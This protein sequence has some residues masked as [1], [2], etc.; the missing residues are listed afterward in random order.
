M[1]FSV[2]IPVFNKARFVPAAV[3]S[4]LAQTLAPLEVIV[5][6]D[7]STDGSAQALAAIT[8]P[9]LRVL[10]QP[11]GGVSA[12]RNRGIDEAA[13]D[14]IAFL[15]AD[16]AYHPRFLE[17]LAQAHRL[18]PEAD[19]LATRFHTVREPTGQPFA[20]W[21][22]PADGG[23][24][25]RVDDLRVRWMRNACLCSSSVA[26][27]AARLKAMRP[28][29]IDGESHGE[30]LDMWFRIA[31]QAPVALVGGAF[32]TVRGEVPGSLTATATAR[33]GMPP[34][35][36]RMRQQ[37]LDG[38]LPPRHRASALWFIA[39]MQVTMARQALAEGRRGEALGWLL[40]ARG[41]GSRRW[42]ITL[43]MALA[44]PARAVDRWQRW[45]L[46]A[47]EPLSKEAV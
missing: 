21:P 1:K 37:A 46:R 47:A 32:A 23:P 25:E 20:P 27:R 42:W 4:A 5:I 16:D 45:R 44:L 17:V 8:D 30:D 11:N 39:Q 28:R 26:A 12:A 13:G 33:R 40:R 18:H 22:V 9:R 29:F 41:L 7:G 19:L 2:V 10:R 31:D 3:A 24:V 38:T 34:F 35:L 15:D 36:V 43:A 14:W 6:D